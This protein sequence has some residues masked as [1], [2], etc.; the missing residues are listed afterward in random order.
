M[1]VHTPVL[2]DEVVGYLKLQPGGLYVD[3]TVG[4][5]GHAERIL[6]GTQPDGQLIALDRDLQLL[7]AARERLEDF[8]G[9]VRFHHENFRQLDCVLD[10]ED[11]PPADG[12]L[13]DLG[14]SSAQ[15]SQPERG[16][17]FLQEGPL[18]MR[19]DQGAGPTA[20]DLLNILGKMD[21]VRIFREYGEERYARRIAHTVVQKR[22]RVPMT[23]TTQLAQLI[24]AAVPGRSRK[25]RIHPATRVFQALRMAVNDELPALQSVLEIAVGKLKRGGRLCVISFH[26]LEDRIVKHFFRRL[27]SRGKIKVMTKRPVVSGEEERAR[28]P[29]CRSAKLRVAEGI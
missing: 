15:L 19:M 14:L 3:C 4:E 1:A 12:I 20:A 13:L 11:A 8:K 23:H 28:N 10:Q 29:K 17:S 26:S 25:Y 27:Q 18:D 7:K 2:A 6:Q 5:G 22:E 24:L 16:F 21:L 9:R